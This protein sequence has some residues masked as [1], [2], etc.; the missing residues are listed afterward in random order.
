MKNV[1]PPTPPPPPCF[2]ATEDYVL[3]TQHC[4]NLPNRT[5]P[6]HRYL[7]Y[8]LWDSAK[9]RE[10]NVAVLLYLYIVHRNVA[11]TSKLS[12]DDRR[13]NRMKCR[14]RI[15]VRFRAKEFQQHLHYL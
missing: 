10:L 9:A 2:L 6:G 5:S 14:Q 13:E 12:V 7:T 3:P 8:Q 15:T 4:P 1:K 11:S